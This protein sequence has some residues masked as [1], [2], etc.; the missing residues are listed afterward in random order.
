MCTREGLRR[1]CFILICIHCP[2]TRWS[3]ASLL[4]K[5]RDLELKENKG[6]ALIG[7]IQVPRVAAVLATAHW[8]AV[9][10]AGH[11]EVSQ[12]ENWKLSAA[13]CSSCL[14]PLCSL[15]PLSP[16]YWEHLILY[17]NDSRL[18]FL[19]CLVLCSASVHHTCRLLHR[20]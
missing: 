18:G 17:C 5:W 11:D 14:F 19:S 8:P 4:Y 20:A 10:V 16:P 9:K 6:V 3:A 12:Q 2:L 7:G 1:I 13:G 15:A